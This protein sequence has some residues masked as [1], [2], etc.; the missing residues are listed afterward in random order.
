MDFQ[1]T[2]QGQSAYVIGGANNPT[3]TLT[4]GQTYTFAAPPD[5]PLWITTMR[6]AD[7]AETNRY[8]QGVTNNGLAPSLLTFVVPA[9]P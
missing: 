3:L 9:S 7:D 4:R 2:N 6:G 1:V 5:H 8:S